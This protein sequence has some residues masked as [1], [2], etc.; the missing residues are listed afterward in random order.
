MPRLRLSTFRDR[1]LKACS[2]ILD[3]TLFTLIC[4]ISDRLRELIANWLNYPSSICFWS[5]ICLFLVSKCSLLLIVI[6][7]AL[8]T[9]Y[10]SVYFLVLYGSKSRTVILT[11]IVRGKKFS[12]N[13]INAK[14]STLS[15]CMLKAPP[16]FHDNWRGHYIWDQFNGTNKLG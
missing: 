15:V 9:R 10:L 6:W 14:I 11:S 8:S 7:S 4:Y 13:R 5:H 2:N 12:Q 16:M 1:N 3:R